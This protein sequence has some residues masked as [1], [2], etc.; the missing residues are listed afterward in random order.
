MT[1]NPRTLRHFGFHMVVCSVA[2]AVCLVIVN[3]A[4]VFV[5]LLNAIGSGDE[6]TPTVTNAAN[7]I[8]RM[9][10]TFWPLAASS[11]IAVAGATWLVYRKMVS[12]FPRIRNILAGLAEGRIGETMHLR[13]ADYLHYEAAL[14]NDGNRTLARTIINL[15]SLH[16]E[17][18]E[19][20]FDVMER[21][22]ELRDEKLLEQMAELQN[23][24]KTLGTELDRYVPSDRRYHPEP[25]DSG[26]DSESD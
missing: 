12:P 16:R 20:L 10:T 4:L 13:S 15:Q 22:R 8:V 26:V 19:I 7:E 25:T 11:L 21:A 9:H 2:V 3:A 24:A 14:L 17:M 23:H 5:P 6:I 18:D 1:M